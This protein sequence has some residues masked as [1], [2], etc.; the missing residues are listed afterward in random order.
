MLV[1]GYAQTSPQE[2][3]AIYAEKVLPRLALPADQAQRYADLLAQALQ[4]AG[5]VDL[6]EQ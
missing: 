1:A 2:M 5:L 6:P 3:T 4:D